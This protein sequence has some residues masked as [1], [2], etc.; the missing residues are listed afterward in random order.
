MVNCENRIAAFILN[1][2]TIK[3]F[4]SA[5]PIFE[6]G[7]VFLRN[8][9]FLLHA[10]D[11]TRICTTFSALNFSCFK[12]KFVKVK[13]IDFNRAVSKLQYSFKDW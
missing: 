2:V 6:L 4:L 13:K 3:T 9:N 11:E 12:F 5:I 8:W 10:F 7:T 1:S